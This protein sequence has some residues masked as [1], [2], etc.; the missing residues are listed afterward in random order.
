MPEP[1][2]AIDPA[3]GKPVVPPPE[4]QKVSITVDEL[5]SL[6]S[7]AAKLDVFEKMGPSFGAPAPAP[8]APAGPSLAD[9]VKDIDTKIESLDAKIDEAASNQKPISKL[10]R[11]RDDLNAKRIRLQIQHEDINPRMSAGIQTLNDLTS[12]IVKGQMP[13]LDIVKKEY[14]SF[15]NNIPEESRASLQARQMA[16]N[17]ACGQNM[18]KIIAAKKEEFLREATPNPATPQ[19]SS[20]RGKDTSGADIPE[21]KDILGEGAMQ[22]LKEKGQTADDYYRRLGYA[23]YT[24]WWEKTG[25]EYFAT[26]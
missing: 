19:T 15:L 11:Q 6:K 12:E 9:Q 2:P 18:D 16:Y 14:D 1:T 23:G 8:A 4:P 25:K 3:T 7:A 20:G 5:T 24:D 22:A 17:L 21:P 10:L 26:T 13:Y